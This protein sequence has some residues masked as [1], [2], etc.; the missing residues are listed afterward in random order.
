MQ[1]FYFTSYWCPEPLKGMREAE[2]LQAEL[3]PARGMLKI[4][5]RSM[6]GDHS[7]HSVRIGLKKLSG[8]N[9][10]FYFLA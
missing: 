7:S 4:F 2:K 1:I 5:E 6:M 10:T 3:T 9:G 8:D